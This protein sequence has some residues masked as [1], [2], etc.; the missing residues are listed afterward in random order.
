MLSLG[1]WTAEIIINIMLFPDLRTLGKEAVCSSC[2]GER[3]GEGL[4]AGAMAF[5]GSTEN[6]G[7]LAFTCSPTG[8]QGVPHRFSPV[9]G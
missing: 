6:P 7:Y 9:G 5:W 1:L 3:C 2:S 8:F 4:L